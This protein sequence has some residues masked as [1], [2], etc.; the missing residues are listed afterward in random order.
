[1]MLSGLSSHAGREPTGKAERA[2]RRERLTGPR[3][4]A[5]QAQAVRWPR[6][7]REVG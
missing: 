5:A 4:K 1:M 2:S 7:K 6:L 3:K